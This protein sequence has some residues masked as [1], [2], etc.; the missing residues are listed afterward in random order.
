MLNVCSLDKIDQSVEKINRF[1]DNFKG[2]TP[3]VL[4]LSSRYSYNCSL[5]HAELNKHFVIIAM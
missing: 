4:H 1:R 3:L 5:S 2:A